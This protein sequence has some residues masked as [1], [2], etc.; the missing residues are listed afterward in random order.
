[1]AEGQEGETVGTPEEIAAARAEHARLKAEGA[2]RADVLRARF[3]I[4]RLCRTKSGRRRTPMDARLKL[5]Q[6][7]EAAVRRAD[8]GITELTRG[9]NLADLVERVARIGR[10]PLLDCLQKDMGSP[11]PKRR[12]RAVEMAFTLVRDLVDLYRSLQGAGKRRSG[13]PE[14]PSWPSEAQKT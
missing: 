8:K 3:G 7:A 14:R 11:E 10:G 2:P 4:A 13:R 12:D 1:M 9:V 6:D 5:A